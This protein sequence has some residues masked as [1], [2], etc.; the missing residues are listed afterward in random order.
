[1]EKKGKIFQYRERLDKTLASLELA[2][3]DSLKRLVK[4]QIQGFSPKE[5][6]G[7]YSL[8][9]PVDDFEPP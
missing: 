1:M 3:K 7:L 9:Y 4:N 6:E 5:T 2:N 8:K